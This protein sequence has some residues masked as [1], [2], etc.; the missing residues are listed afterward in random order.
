MPPAHRVGYTDA[1]WCLMKKAPQLPTEEF[2]GVRNR[3]DD[4][5]A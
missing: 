5:V 4:F 3:F 1:I 2:P